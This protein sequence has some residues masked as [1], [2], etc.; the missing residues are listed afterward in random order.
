MPARLKADIKIVR[1]HRDIRLA[2][3]Y[4]SPNSP[5][6][7]VDPT[8]HCHGKFLLNQC[9]TGVLDELVS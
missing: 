7:C 1:H 3:D 5:E 4:L 8:V 2:F 9:G 6:I